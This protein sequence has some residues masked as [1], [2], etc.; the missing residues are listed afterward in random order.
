MALF[1]AG[2]GRTEARFRRFQEVVAQDVCGRASSVREEIDFVL[3][4]EDM[5][6]GIC[7]LDL[8]TG[9]DNKGMHSS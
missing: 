1:V 3:K 5:V 9:A 4:Y 8:N 6:K 7:V 2:S